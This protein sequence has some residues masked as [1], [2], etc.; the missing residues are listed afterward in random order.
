MSDWCVCVS[1]LCGG[2]S[3][4]MGVGKMMSVYLRASKQLLR[5]I[6]VSGKRVIRVS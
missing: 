6:R 3:D 1:S 2:E 5:F 4:Y